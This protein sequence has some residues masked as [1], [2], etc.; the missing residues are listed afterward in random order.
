MARAVKA[1]RKGG[2]TAALNELSFDFI[3]S[4]Y[5]RVI[6]VDGAFGGVSPTGRGIH[7]AVYSERRPLPRKTVHSLE[8]DGS[9][10]DELRDKRETRTALV[11]E[12]EADL[13]MDLLTATAV[14][15]WLNEKII[16]L[17]ELSPP[18]LVRSLAP[19]DDK[20]T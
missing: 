13:V 3:K 8:E 18:E 6:C 7:M 10:G 11:R 1:R 9:L 16:Q 2:K 19:E 17:A 4:N 14:R 12:V 15:D 20:T 5:F